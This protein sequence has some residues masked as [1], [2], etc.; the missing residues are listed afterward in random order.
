MDR[1]ILLITTETP[2]DG[3]QNWR[4][5][6]LDVERRRG[7]SGANW[8]FINGIA[9]RVAIRWQRPAAPIRHLAEPVRQIFAP[10][11]ESLRRI[12]S[13]E[14]LNGRKIKVTRGLNAQK[15][16]KQRTATDP[17]KQTAR[18]DAITLI[19][20]VTEMF[21]RQHLDGRVSRRST[22]FQSSKWSS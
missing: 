12:S 15:K 20:N 1:L 22:W 17:Q 4:P 6:S 19:R 2:G 8:I 14:M 3:F 18:L 7:R 9:N 11:I 10:L 13:V 16:G 5:C 21:S